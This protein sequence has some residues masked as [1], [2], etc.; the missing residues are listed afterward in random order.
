MARRVEDKLTRRAGRQAPQHDALSEETC[1]ETRIDVSSSLP[2][3]HLDTHSKMAP[4]YK[5][6][7]DE[8]ADEHEAKGLLSASSSSGA[9]EIEK[10]PAAG[11]PAV[12]AVKL[13]I[14]SRKGDLPLLGAL[15]SSVFF[16]GCLSARPRACYPVQ[17]RSLR[18]RVAA[19]VRSLCP[20]NEAALAPVVARYTVW[21]ILYVPHPR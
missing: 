4:E 19:S 5:A 16:S 12:K 11:E 10:D 20:A 15:C 2:R 18:I 17:M 21:D 7:G 13:R 9:L 8:D 6:V 3:P 1:F 14:G